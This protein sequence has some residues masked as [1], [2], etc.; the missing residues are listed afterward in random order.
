MLVNTEVNNYLTITDDASVQLY[1]ILPWSVV[2]DPQIL[3]LAS[4]TKSNKVRWLES[5][6]GISGKSYGTRGADSGLRSG[7]ATEE[8]GP[9]GPQ[10]LTLGLD[11]HE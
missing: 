8:Q 6:A 5:L 10:L 7:N 11:P 4:Q 2:V 3:W 9:V 1:E